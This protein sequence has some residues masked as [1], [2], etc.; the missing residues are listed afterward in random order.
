MY[1]QNKKKLLAIR[2]FEA[3]KKYFL[4]LLEKK[5]YIYSYMC[6]VVYK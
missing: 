4:F 5:I 2:Y 6:I 3:R 1:T